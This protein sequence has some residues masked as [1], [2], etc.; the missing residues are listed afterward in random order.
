M[1]PC[2]DQQEYE[3]PAL[4]KPNRRM[5]TR[6]SVIAFVGRRVMP[7]KG[8]TVGACG[9]YSAYRRHADRFGICITKESF[10]RILDRHGY[11]RS[12]GRFGYVYQ[13]LKLA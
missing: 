12:F 11:R 9:L 4:A 8:Q 2:T 6:Q 13:N 10:C 3:M 5:T 1:H 7:A